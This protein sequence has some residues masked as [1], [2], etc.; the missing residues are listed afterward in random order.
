MRKSIILI[1]LLA[2][3]STANAAATNLLVN[4][5]FETGDFTGWTTWNWGGAPIPYITSTDVYDGNYAAACP[6]NA[7]G[8][9]GIYQWID[10]NDANTGEI[11]AFEGY[12]K[13]SGSNIDCTFIIAY[14]DTVDGTEFGRNERHIGSQ[15][16]WTFGQAI[17]VI[18]PGVGAIKVEAGAGGSA[19]TGTAYFDA[20]KT[21]IT[22]I[23]PIIN[24]DDPNVWVHFYQFSSTDSNDTNFVSTGGGFSGTGKGNYNFDGK[25][26]LIIDYD[27]NTAA[28]G[29][30]DVTL[31]ETVNRVP[32]GSGTLLPTQSLAELFEFD[33]LAGSIVSD[34]HLR[35]ELL[36]NNGTFP[37][38]DIVLD[39]NLLPDSIEITGGFCEAMFDGFHYNLSNASARISADIA[40][41]A[42]VS[43][44]DF[45]LF[46]QQ[47][48]NTNCGSCD[49]ADFTRDGDVDLD[50]LEIFTNL[51]P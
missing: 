18:P 49:G 47:W 33:M 21:T 2:V 16:D 42:G 9:S 8:G 22:L 12:A 20:F 35:F 29:F 50:D 34:T 13:T 27:S 41:P 5:G 25:I 39:V 28:F 19:E 1:T 10:V 40:P 36:R 17:G 26:Q 45:A 4:P 15:T 38:A 31:T 32:Y 24:P 48:P 51:W 37:C 14:F 43:L 46:A 23:P 3:V 44:T 11:V 7:S 30:C 6:R